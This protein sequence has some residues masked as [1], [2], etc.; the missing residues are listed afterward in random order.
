MRDGQVTTWPLEVIIVRRL[1]IRS[2]T[3]GTG[4][5]EPR[6][7]PRADVSPGPERHPT[8]GHAP[9]RA[10]EWGLGHRPG[11]PFSGQMKP[12]CSDVTDAKAPQGDSPRRVVGEGTDTRREPVGRTKT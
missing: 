10:D 6:G 12:T 7:V 9:P 3:S 5:P 8:L 2:C 4:T 1:V 11:G